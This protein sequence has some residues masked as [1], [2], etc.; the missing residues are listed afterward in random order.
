MPGN[1]SFAGRSGG[2][3]KG[4]KEEERT[5]GHCCGVGVED[6]VATMRCRDGGV[7]EA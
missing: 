1:V 5:Y 4:E 3:Q 2:R 7:V 6:V